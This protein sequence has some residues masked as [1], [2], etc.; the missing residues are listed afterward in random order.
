MSVNDLARI[1]DEKVQILNDQ[2]KQ[3]LQAKEELEDS[4]ASL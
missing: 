2:V 3:L 4:L 1:G